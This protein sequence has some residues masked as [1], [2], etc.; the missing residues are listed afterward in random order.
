MNEKTAAKAESLR[1]WSSFGFEDSATG[2]GS[3]QEGVDEN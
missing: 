2:P 3:E 1:A